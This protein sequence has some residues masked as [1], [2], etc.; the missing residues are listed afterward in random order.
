M[1][2]MHR[3]AV[4]I[5]CD[6]GPQVWFYCLQVV[7]HQWQFWKQIGASGGPQS[8]SQHGVQR[9]SCCE[10]ERFPDQIQQPD[11]DNVTHSAGTEPA[12]NPL[13]EDTF[14]IVLGGWKRCVSL[15]TKGFFVELNHVFCPTYFSALLSTVA[16][17]RCLFI[18]VLSILPGPGQGG[19]GLGYL[20]TPLGTPL[21][22]LC[23]VNYI[24]YS[25]IKGW[26][27]KF[28]CQYGRPCNDIQ[29]LIQVYTPGRSLRSAS[30]G[31]LLA[32]P[33]A[34]DAVG[35]RS[36]S[37]MAPHLWNSLSDSLRISAT[38]AQFKSNLKIYP[39]REHFN[40]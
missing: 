24:G 7:D 13:I 29:R 36:F 5:E 25:S 21:S 17:C 34:S 14:L 28:F 40:D 33:R 20:E 10:H 38:K 9:P 32:V 26:G 16:T 22:S 3:D 23:F 30:S 19:G 8:R 6:I 39:F 11:L 15:K 27:I 4:P 18:C 31:P 2:L 37:R 1:C 12:D 35:G